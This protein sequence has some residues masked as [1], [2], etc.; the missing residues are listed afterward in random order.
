LLFGAGVVLVR[1]VGRSPCV[2]LCAILNS[3][4]ADYI[5]SFELSVCPLVSDM[6][7]N[8]QFRYS[9]QMRETPRERYAAHGELFTGCGVAVGG[10]RHV[11]LRIA[12]GSL[13][14]GGV[15]VAKGTHTN[16]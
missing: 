12:Y 13:K 14:L 15:R 16:G 2:G 10:V 1:R 7:I 8:A 4:V 6:V 9:G 3:P 11:G 5:S